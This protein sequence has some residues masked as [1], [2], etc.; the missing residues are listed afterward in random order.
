MESSSVPVGGGGAGG[1]DFFPHFLD[2]EGIEREVAST[3]LP[4]YTRDNAR[5]RPG[6][7]EVMFYC[8]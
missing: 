1:D 4:R 5:P 6:E 2:G 3:D 8:V 7:R